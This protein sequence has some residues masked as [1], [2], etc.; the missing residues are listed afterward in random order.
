MDP[1]VD[2]AKNRRSV[3]SHAMEV[4][5]CGNWNVVRSD[6]EERSHNLSE[7]ISRRRCDD[8]KNSAYFHTMVGRSCQHA[9]GWEWPK[10]AGDVGDWQCM[11]G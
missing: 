4:T 6:F 1:S 9:A 2:A 5:A 10:T 8:M 3:T 7:P 11:V